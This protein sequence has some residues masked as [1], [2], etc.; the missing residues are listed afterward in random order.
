MISP[1]LQTE[2]K[3]TNALPLFSAKHKQTQIEILAF[4]VGHRIEI[5]ALRLVSSLFLP[6]RKHVLKSFGSQCSGRSKLKK[7]CIYNSK[8]SKIIMIFATRF[9]KPASA[10]LLELIVNVGSIKIERKKAALDDTAQ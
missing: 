6:P 4:I 7:I 3:N 2:T 8:R 10:M 1:L 5:P 9:I